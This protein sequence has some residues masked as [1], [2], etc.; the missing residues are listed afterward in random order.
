MEDQE[1]DVD[2]GEGD[3]TRAEFDEIFPMVNIRSDNPMKLQ[4][5]Y[6]RN[7]KQEDSRGKEQFRNFRLLEK[8]GMLADAETYAEMDPEYAAVMISDRNKR[9]RR[10]ARKVRRLSLCQR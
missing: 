9:I 2:D 10:R 5:R 6:L 4:R 7:Y 1:E 3:V 8:A